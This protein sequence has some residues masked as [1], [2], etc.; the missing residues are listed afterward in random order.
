[1]SHV[2]IGPAGCVC[3]PTCQTPVNI[4]VSANHRLQAFECLQCGQ[5]H[6]V[7]AATDRVKGPIVW[8]A[9]DLTLLN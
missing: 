4:E 3:C 7:T 2:T 1:M 9:G 8:L 5:I 6:Q